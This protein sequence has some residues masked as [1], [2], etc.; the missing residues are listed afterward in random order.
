MFQG[1]YPYRIDDK[2]RLKVPAEFV[3]GLGASFTITRG[4]DGCLWVLPEAEWQAMV[5]RL[6]GDSILD[7]RALAL[8]RW[9]IGSAH[10]VSLDAQGRLTLPQVLRDL[11]GIEH[12]IVVI[13]GGIRVEIWSRERWQAYESRL[14]DELIAEL[15]RSAGL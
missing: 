4:H 14:N 1:T 12:E 5:N 11:A 3:H 6:S 10:T 13:G 15:A 9:F 8:Q 7:Q 2:G